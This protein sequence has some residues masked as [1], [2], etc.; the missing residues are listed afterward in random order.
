MP[1]PATK[2][3]TLRATLITHL[4][5]GHQLDELTF[6]RLKAEIKKI[7]VDFEKIMLMPLLLAAYGKFEEAN[8]QFKYGI[9]CYPNVHLYCDYITYLTHTINFREAYQISLQAYEL[10]GR[11][12]GVPIL[13]LVYKVCTHFIDGD[14]VLKVAHDLVALQPDKEEQIML[15]AKDD[16]DTIHKFIS[17]SDVSPDIARVMMSE[18]YNIAAANKADL[19]Q[20]KYMMFPNECGL[21]LCLNGI[22]PD[23]ASDM[24][25]E[26]AMAFAERDM[27][28]PQTCSIWFEANE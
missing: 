19:Y 22:T 10:F 28:V 17:R 25:F 21:V 26:L 9:G 3:S 11:S 2:T 16:A 14:T 6:R 4:E 24:N 5:S 7:P 1:V 13:E 15:M 20:L 8:E 18:A 23:H 27:V 12:Y